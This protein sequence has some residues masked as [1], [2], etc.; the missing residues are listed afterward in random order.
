VT[1]SSSESPS[2]LSTRILRAAATADTV[3]FWAGPGSVA[4]DATTHIVRFLGLILASD[5]ELHP[6]ELNL[7]GRVMEAMLG[8]RPTHDDLQLAAV[9]GL[10]AATDPQALDA[11]IHS[12]PA[13]LRAL[14]EMDRTHRTREA[15]GVV[16]ALGALGYAVLEADGRAT[17]EEGHV[18]R[19]HINHLREVLAREEVGGEL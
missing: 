6:R 14:I 9:E 2:E 12:T 16:R 18:F 8:E 4:A 7:Y 13:Y 17:S 15:L 5:Q 11:F 3:G 10:D 19:G 1:P